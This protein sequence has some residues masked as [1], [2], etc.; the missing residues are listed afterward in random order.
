[1]TSEGRFWCIGTFYP[2]ISGLWN[3]SK[4]LNTNPHR[5]AL[6]FERKTLQTIGLYLNSVQ[7][8]GPPKST[9]CLVLKAAVFYKIKDLKFASLEM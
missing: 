4:I 7:N 3:N 6:H 9:H 2:S 5:V 1:M 8:G